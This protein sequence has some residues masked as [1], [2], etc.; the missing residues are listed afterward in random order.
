[1]TRLELATLCGNERLA[2]RFYGSLMQA[3]KDFGIDTPLRQAHFLAQIMHESG[4][5]RYTKELWGPTDAQKRYEGRKDLGNTEPGDGFKFRGRGLIQTTG[6]ANYERVG[7]ALGFNLINNPDGLADVS[8]ACRS[9]A[10]FWYDNDLNDLADHDDI[11][12]V[13]R[14]VNGGKNGLEDRTKYLTRAKKLLGVA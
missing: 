4:G 6:R 10:Y 1:M 13:T 12:R 7:K 5:L 14:R 3:M 2:D 9:A 8:L 11:V